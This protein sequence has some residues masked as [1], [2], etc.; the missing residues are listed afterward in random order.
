MKARPLLIALSLVV[1]A[2]ASCPAVAQSFSGP[3]WYDY[4]D[5][6]FSVDG[7]GTLLNPIVITTPEQ[8]A[9]L[10][11]IVNEQHNPLQGKVVTLAE[12]IDLAKVADGK[13]VEWVPIG[14][15]TPFGGVFLGVSVMPGADGP[16]IE[17]DGH[18]ISGMYIDCTVTDEASYYGLFGRCEGF[19]GYLNLREA[20]L[21]LTSSGQGWS[22]PAIVAGLLCGDVYNLDNLTLHEGVVGQGQDGK[23][24]VVL[25]G[26]TSVSVQGTM[27]VDGSDQSSFGGIC[28]RLAKGEI[29]HSTA[30]VSL[31]NNGRGQALGG[32]AGQLG[33]DNSFMKCSVTDC[34][35]NV[36][37]SLERDIAHIGGI[38]GLANPET[39]VTGCSSSGVVKGRLSSYAGG[40]VGTQGYKSR[41]VSSTSVVSFGD[42]TT[43]G[44]L[45]VGG[46]T[47][48]L[49]EG[50]GE[51]IEGCVYGG[52]IDGTNAINVGGICGWYSGSTDEHI[53]NSL[54]LGT[55]VPSKRN[56]SHNGA[57]VGDTPKPI[58]TVSACY[59]DRQLFSGDAS[60]GFKTVVSITPLD[61]RTMTSGESTALPL[62]PADDSGDY[63]FTFTDGYYPMAF[64][65]GKT[66][67]QEVMA[68][69]S[70]DSEI[71]RKLF[72]SNLRVDNSLYQTVAWLA[73][74]PV[75]VLHGDSTDDFV[76]T[77]TLN[78]LAFTQTEADGRDVR[79]QT[80]A[81]LSE[82]AS[83]TVD[84][85][86]VTAKA[87]GSYVFSI[88]C[89][90]T[91]KVGSLLVMARPRPLGCEK[92]VTLN[93]TLGTPWDGTTA[94]QCAAGAGTAED[95]FIVKNGAQLAYA[96]GNNKAGQFYEQIC[97]IV[98]N[99]N[100]ISDTG[101]EDFNAKP[102]PQGHWDARYDG[103]SHIV[104]GM[105]TRY[106]GQGLFGDIGSKGEVANLGVAQSVFSR[107]GS[108]ILARNVDGRVYNCFVQG[109]VNPTPSHS[110]FQS[111]DYAIS[112]SGG[113][114]ATIGLGNAAAVVE[115][116]ISAV[117][118][119][120]VF[121]DYTPFVCLNE[122][123]KGTV[124]NCLAVVPTYFADTNWENFDF[125]ADGHPYIKDCYWLQG[126]ESMQTGWTLEEIGEALGNAGR[127]SWAEGY[128]PT[129]KSFAESDIA[130][131]MTVAVR[132]DFVDHL[133]LPEQPHYVS[134]NAP[135]HNM[136]LGFGHHLEFTPGS[137]Q[138]KLTGYNAEHFVDADSDM[139]IITPLST[140]I[141]PSYRPIPAARG[142]PGLV[143]LKGTLGD[144]SIL[145]PIRTMS[146]SVSKGITF[147]DDNAR[148]ACL[149]AFDTNGNGFI[150]LAELR[151]ITAEQTANA[152][153]TATARKIKS[154]PE[155]RF[156]KNV[157]RLTTQLVGLSALEDVQLPYALRT[158]GPEAFSGCSNL[159]TVDI[160]S[161]VTTVEPRAF[162]GSSVTDIGVD[163][164]NEN[165]EER[166]GVLFTTGS[167]LVSYPNGRTDEEAV[168]EGTVR[169]IAEGAF[170]K[171]P[172]LRRLYFDTTNYN[173]VPRLANGAIVTDQ[174]DM[175]D[176]Y[177]SDA[178]YDQTL[179][180][181][182]RDNHSWEAYAKAGRLHQYY[183]LKVDETLFSAD[184][185][186]PGA[187]GSYLTT[188]CIGFDTALPRELTPYIVTSA[189]REQYM[190]TL[191]D[192][193][194][195]VP[196]TTAVV[197]A[198]TKPGLYRLR[199]LEDVGPLTPWPL[200]ENRLVG[201]DRNGL[202]LNQATSAQGSIMT[203]QP[204]PSATI[205]EA[206]AEGPF[207]AAAT[208]P[209]ASA[210][211]PTLGFYAEKQKSIPPYRAYLPYN[212]VGLDP[213]VA[214]K[215]HYDIE[216]NYT[217]PEADIVIAD[218]A[219]NTSLLE[220]Y[221]GKLVNVTYD[222]TFK[223]TLNADGTWANR[224]YTV[225]LPYDLNLI[226]DAHRQASVRLYRLIAVTDDYEFV[227]TNEFNYISAGVPYL[228]V[229]QEGEMRLDGQK[230]KISA[231]PKESDTFNYVSTTY[232]R[233]SARF[234]NDDTEDVA[235]SP[236]QAGWWRGT[237]RIIG[238][239]EASAMH[240]FAM[241]TDGNWRVV[242]NDQERYRTGRLLPFRAYYQPLVHKNNHLYT[243]KY[244]YTEQGDSGSDMKEA[245]P[246]DTFEGDLFGYDDDTEGVDPV[247]HTIDSDGTHRYFD[248][249]GRPLDRRPDKGIYIEKGR[250]TVGAK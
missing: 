16:G 3:T 106:E 118:C 19:I 100:L 249:Q 149:E 8:L 212:T 217:Q 74:V 30:D 58:E 79:L 97:D 86:T 96:V 77:L 146:G 87:A 47:G 211:G 70:P 187:Q 128:F 150:S 204:A 108:G 158:I 216:F 42:V 54:F 181:K 68:S 133:P 88:V 224:A 50:G 25:P 242:R 65:K 163:H 231:K 189:D 162:Y 172:G 121:A 208:I 71:G 130:K 248:L 110:S 81:M 145:I 220:K 125:S 177:V 243:P 98:L 40:I 91:V 6:T 94:T 60:G 155:F 67:C 119:T 20:S 201:T 7:K 12:D 218:N 200:Y 228:L 5:Q 195:Q 52:S 18:R 11:W 151:T 190:A 105:Y 232:G 35:A 143:W 137:A 237:Y 113:I 148:Q 138:W 199:P 241:S 44:S 171:V 4:R 210:E 127:W 75:N 142:I 186:S 178:T 23:S 78:N 226:D 135:L 14:M 17:T 173:T 111:K 27:T 124:R 180:R 160:P 144:A 29:S 37:F 76:S 63:G 32:I 245:F 221:D 244:V 250:I 179:I 233:A 117:F 134:P 223:A 174:G 184:C 207:S 61:T 197:I 31:V 28:G 203:M 92:R 167:A 72:G 129:L 170:Y 140:S 33:I 46:I 229:V 66:L 183:P 215:A 246:A 126:Y 57:I 95:P 185:K 230:V 84:D 101:S 112:G 99:T 10:S 43:E 240:A 152:F 48:R 159:T 15:S 36:N 139:G 193:P 93:V 131:L 166:D 21:T 164:F 202:P 69:N 2:L 141:D 222:R 175:L 198:A 247:I 49:G 156:F 24:L 102:W 122:Q 205:P 188:M 56:G 89:H 85:L 136:L 53:T 55:L 109:V 132:T 161:K 154:F 234:F 168:I 235:T 80:E 123:N 82:S 34:A 116:C 51:M 13:R 219:D 120:R 62:L 206:S 157:T 38:T 114:C 107:G 209:E 147:V 194:R 64:Y 191:T 196:A 225:C 239:D 238:N 90:P 22:R 39:D 104:Y 236:D 83:V 214:A 103:L 169:S 59:Y 45:C 165:F 26:V 192:R 227:F 41:V 73:S 115:D 1:C 176:V 213:D 182:Y 9:Q 153:Q